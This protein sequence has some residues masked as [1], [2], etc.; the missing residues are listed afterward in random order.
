MPPSASEHG[1]DEWGAGLRRDPGQGAGEGQA[2]AV[3]HHRKDQPDRACLDS[4]CTYGNRED[5]HCEEDIAKFATKRLLDDK[6][7]S[8]SDLAEFGHDRIAG[9]QQTRQR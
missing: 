6:R 9:S 3:A 1:R 5:H 4:Q 8:A 2:V 7:K